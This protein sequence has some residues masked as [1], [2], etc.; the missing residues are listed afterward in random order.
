MSDQTTGYIKSALFVDFDNIFIGLQ[1][2]D[3]R[4]AE[5]FARDPLSWIEWLERSVAVPDGAGG[6]DQ[7]RRRLL[8]RRCYLNPR[9]FNR[10]RAFFIASGFEVVDTPPLTGQG[11]TSA[12]M[13]MVLDLV[14]ALN[15]PTR[16]DEFIVFSGDADFTPLLLRLRKHDRRSLVLAV[17]Y[18]SSAYR[19]AC[20]H[21]IDQETFV[22][23]AL[24][25]EGAPDEPAGGDRPAPS[26]SAEQSAERAEVLERI[27]RRIREVVAMMG[28]IGAADVPQVYKE[29]PEFTSGEN[30]LDFYSLRRMTE[31][32][33]EAVG[34][35]EIV[36]EDAWRI[37][38][39]RAAAPEAEPA[40]PAAPPHFDEIRDF[41]VRTV[42]DS[43][44]PVVLGAMAHEVVRR[45][46]DEVKEHDW[47]YAG[48]FKAFLERL[49]L[50]GIEIAPKIPGHLYDPAVHGD[51]DPGDRVDPF[52]VGHPEIAE[53]A[54]AVS[55]VTDTPYLTPEQY[56][57]VFAEIAKEVEENGFQLTRTS[58]AVRDRCNG[59]GIS[60]ARTHISFL[61]KGLSFSGFRF[62]GDGET[63]ER[64]GRTIYRNTLE[65]CR[66]AQ[67]DLSTEDEHRIAEW[68]L[69][70]LGEEVAASA[71][72]SAAA[73]DTGA[74]ADEDEEEGAVALSSA[75]QS[76][77][78]EVPT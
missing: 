46:G 69:G 44:S 50:D 58:K 65:L 40:E 30:W 19:A 59:K 75:T 9:A 42:R 4:A 63:A 56:A 22:E 23:E 49:G 77:Q 17:G 45:F 52:T 71:A 38:P 27:G 11:K 53:L 20:D 72:Q 41:V 3:P 7:R 31:A 60:V 43:P 64:I 37:Q 78:P 15:H 34:D 48:S 68:L 32:V 6:A 66:R 25:I 2:T 21:L 39:K 16:F 76:P 10:F 29:F 74:G 54:R 35:L 8:V 61:L 13:H 62:T 55:D 36:G 18:A 51:F 33:V 14:D 70:G 67:M 12:D 73:A 24:G 28:A 47:Q 5:R 57:V 1:Q 26:V